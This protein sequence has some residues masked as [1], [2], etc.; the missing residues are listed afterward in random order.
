MSDYQPLS[1]G[2]E[3]SIIRKVREFKETLS[4]G[5]YEPRD[6]F[7]LEEIEE[8]IESNS[9]AIKDLQRIVYSRGQEAL[10]IISNNYDV[11]KLIRVLLSLPRQ[12]GMRDPKLLISDRLPNYVSNT[13]RF[14]DILEKVGF[15]DFLSRTGNVEFLVAIALFSE[16]KRR[17]PFQQA[18]NLEKI[19]KKEIEKTIYH[20]DSIRDEDICLHKPDYF[21]E[22]FS[23]NIPKRGI[24]YIISANNIPFA[25][26]NS[27]YY[28]N[29]GGV[30]RRYL[31]SGFPSTQ[32]ALNSIPLQYILIAD[33]YAFES[34]HDDILFTLF[35]SL[36]SVINISQLEGGLLKDV[37]ENALV[38][39]QEVRT[40]VEQ[41]IFSSLESENNV[42]ANNLPID[43]DRARYSLAQFVSQN[44]NLSLSLSS[45]SEELKWTRQSLVVKSIGLEKKFNL[46]KSVE[47]FGDVIGAI[48][49]DKIPDID[50]P[51]YEYF[52][53]SVNPTS[54]FPEKFLVVSTNISPITEENLKDIARNSL[55]LASDTKFTFLVIPSKLDGT[56][57][58]LGSSIQRVLPTNVVILEI[59]TLTNI[60]K[61]KQSPIRQLSGILLEQADLSKLSPFVINSATPK[62]MY[63]GRIQEQAAIINI[64]SSSSVALLGSRR[65]GKTSLLH[66][67]RDSLY[68]AGFNVYFGDCQSVKN[69]E[70]FADLAERKWK[71][72]LP[73]KFDPK[74]VFDLIE[75]LSK[76]TNDK[77]ILLLDEI[78][79]LL[80][81]DMEKTSENVPEPL[82]RTFRTIS[83]EGTAD[84][85]FSGE[86]IIAKKLWDPQSPH[87]NFC[88][89]FPLKQLDKE[90]TSKL[91][92]Q[93]LFDLNISL[94]EEAKFL[95]SVWD[96][97]SGHPQI[98][99]H[100]GNLLIRNL[101]K[102]STSERNKVSIKDLEN[103]VE[104]L[105]FKEHFVIT[106][107]GQATEFEKALSLLVSRGVSTPHKLLSQLKELGTQ[108]SEDALLEAL[109]II[110]L[111]GIVDQIEDGY[112]LNPHWFSHAVSAFG[113]FDDLLSSFL[114]K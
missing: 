76:G 60:L 10:T 113:N 49:V 78:D 104:T 43:H 5:F 75:Q 114:E 91:I 31:N 39:K 7:S 17:L 12:F 96:I 102:R 93:P 105:E 53:V 20:L 92:S 51:Y 11:V 45:D 62:N 98:V 22:I 65:I 23:N 99:Q 13:E 14:V 6:F 42:L 24:D 77:V 2:D 109:R 29:I 3:N 58:V 38:T 63:F 25:A 44:S 103:I 56:T 95:N 48:S 21:P 81:W 9:K 106:Y 73:R 108:V 83:Q 69:W 101:N 68:E 1:F 80:S 89:G 70:V 19:V 27:I 79:Q 84:F 16:K 47:L 86:R 59:K 28:T 61:Q 55:S 36:F 40:P 87:W 52:Y 15:W 33:G 111:Y 90:A 94:V 50:S 34:L 74:H 26:L 37:L 30:Q 72:S 71:V 82:F 35:D 85:V 46:N 57:S 54:I 107:W 4:Q 8:V 100:M 64:L 32:E 97:T 66:R 67:V 110:N 41:I 88:E 112:V 18:R